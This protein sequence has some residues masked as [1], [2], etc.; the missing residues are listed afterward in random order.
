LNAL[1]KAY[2]LAHP[3]TTDENYSKAESVWFK[4]VNESQ[5]VF[6]DLAALG[7]QNLGVAVGRFRT[8]FDESKLDPSLE[9]EVKE[10]GKFRFRL[11]S[12]KNRFELMLS[13]SAQRGLAGHDRQ[14]QDRD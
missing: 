14:T 11:P 1:L 10:E 9:D 6:E 8:A 13:S 3:T 4:E 2:P 7:V 5:H 12:W